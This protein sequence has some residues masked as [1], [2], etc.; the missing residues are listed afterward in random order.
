[1]LGGEK[2]RGSSSRG[3]RRR[4]RL[5]S[6]PRPACWWWPAWPAKSGAPIRAFR[7]M[8]RPRHLG[9]PLVSV[10]RMASLMNGRSC[11]SAKTSEEPR[12]PLRSGNGALAFALGHTRPPRGQRHRPRSVLGQTPTPENHLNYG[13]L[14]RVSQQEPGPLGVATKQPPPTTTRLDSGWTGLLRRSPNGLAPRNDD[15]SNRLGSGW[16]GSSQ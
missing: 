5:R 1:M 7:V 11:R 10:G 14:E 2:H 8:L 4:A 3:A 9:V 12:G 15:R 6:D 13:V 16:V